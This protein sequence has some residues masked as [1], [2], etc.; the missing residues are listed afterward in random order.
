MTSKHVCI[1]VF[2]R[3]RSLIRAVPRVAAV[4]ARAS[5]SAI[6]RASAPERAPI[7]FYDDGHGLKRLGAGLQSLRG[8]WPLMDKAALI[9]VDGLGPVRM[10]GALVGW[11][12]RALRGAIVFEGVC[13]LGLALHTIGMPEDATRRY[14]LMLLH[15]RYL[16]L[17]EAVGSEV[18]AA[19]SEMRRSGA[20]EVESFPDLDTRGD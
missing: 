12:L 13:I 1:G 2:E 8:S 6:G 4:T 10:G 15:G 9:W 11:M 16:I 20:T 14:D 19:L 3:E 7:G 18:E 5:V 17:A